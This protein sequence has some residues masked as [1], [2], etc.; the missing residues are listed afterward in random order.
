MKIGVFV[1]SF[2]PVHRGHIKI[3]KFLLNNYLDEVIIV[4]TGNYW[5]KN[6]LL[7]IEKRINMLKLYEDDR[8]IIDTENNNLEYTYMI[9]DKM[10][11][12][13]KYDTLYLILGADN[14][15]DFDKWK[16]YKKLLK[17]NLIIINRDGIDVYYYLSKF[18]KKDKYIICNNLPNM[19]ISSSEIR[20]DIMNKNYDKL[21]DLID[22]K[23][24]NYIIKYDLYTR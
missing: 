10:S 2:N 13:Y 3:V 15:I 20:Y 18:N 22:D 7:D 11:Q 21:K 16:E 4:P 8:I 17:Y 12:K 1:G 5:N 14:I 19:E 24:L 9:M 6:D 23:I